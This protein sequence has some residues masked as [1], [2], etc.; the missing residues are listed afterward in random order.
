M[1]RKTDNP[2][3]AS[4]HAAGFI[5]IL[6]QRSAWGTCIGQSSINYCL[7][8]LVTRLPFYLVRARH[9]SRFLMSAISSAACGKL[10]DRWIDAGAPPTR[11][12]KGFMGI[13]HVGTGILLVLTNG[14]VAYPTLHPC[15]ALDRD[16]SGDEHR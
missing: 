15:S 6:R 9:L 14:R 2:S 1:P 4:G 5:D 8:F 7:Y 10:S 16:I 3:H 13:G 11:V 12:R